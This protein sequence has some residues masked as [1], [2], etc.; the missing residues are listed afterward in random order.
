ML[1]EH[2]LDLAAELNDAIR[3]MET[4]EDERV[5]E[6]VTE[7]LQRVDLLHRE[8]LLRLVDALRAAG[9]GSALES[10]LQDPIV[11]ILLA[12]YDLADFESTAR[13]RQAFI[14]LEQLRLGRGTAPVAEPT[15]R[16]EK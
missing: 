5:R 7:L 4:H 14:P 13:D 6:H 9:A 12:L 2:Y 3:A 8:G 1:Y 10:A 16:G 11:R 15:P